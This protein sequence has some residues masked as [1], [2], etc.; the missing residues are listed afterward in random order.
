VQ[1]ISDPRRLIYGTQHQAELLESLCKALHFNHI[2]SITSDG[3]RLIS[4]SDDSAVRLWGAASGATIGKFVRGHSDWVT[5]VTFSPDGTR[6]V[7]GSRDN[8]LRL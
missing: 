1:R 4:G 6:V 8:T 7:S 5:P 2:R 3:R